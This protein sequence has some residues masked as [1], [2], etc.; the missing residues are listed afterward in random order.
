MDK[1]NTKVTLAY[2]SNDEL[3]WIYE[4]TGSKSVKRQVT[5]DSYT[6]GTSESDITRRQV[7]GVFE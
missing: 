6:G 3:I 5:D 7:F 4:V 2:N 1:Y